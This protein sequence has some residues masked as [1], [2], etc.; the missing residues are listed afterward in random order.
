MDWAANFG[1]EASTSTSAPD[2]LS[3]TICESTVGSVDS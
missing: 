2:A 3:A 1:N